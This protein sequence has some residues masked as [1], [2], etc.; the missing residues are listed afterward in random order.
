MEKGKQKLWVLSTK[1][2]TRFRELF[3]KRNT[4]LGI[5]FNSSEIRKYTARFCQSSFKTNIAV[6]RW[7]LEERS[8][9]GWKEGGKSVQ[10]RFIF[11]IFHNTFVLPNSR[12]TDFRLQNN[13]NNFSTEDKTEGSLPFTKIQEMISSWNEDFDQSIPLGI[14]VSLKKIDSDKISQITNSIWALYEYGAHNDSKNM[15]TNFNRCMK[16]SY[17]PFS[18]CK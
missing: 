4:F 11:F 17:L 16:L 9:D 14:T 5:H 6:K 2:K 10:T 1:I 13:Q 12:Q 3:R 18:N 8:L 15:N 7:T